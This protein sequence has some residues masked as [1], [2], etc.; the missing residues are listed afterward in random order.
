ME[1]NNAPPLDGAMS[2]FSFV[3][4]GKTLSLTPDAVK[5]LLVSQFQSPSVQQVVATQLQQE[6][7][8]PIVQQGHN[9]YPF[10]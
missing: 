2:T 8:T 1:N 6:N 5:Q 4:D 10:S 7:Q 3:V 9:P